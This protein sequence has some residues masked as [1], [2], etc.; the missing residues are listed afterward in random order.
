VIAVNGVSLVYEG[1]EGAHVLKDITFKAERGEKIALIG[2]NGAGKSSLLL[3]ISGVLPLHEGTISVGGVSVE[4]RNLASA[5][6]LAGLVFQ[7]P[8]D[9]LFMPTIWEDVMFGPRNYARLEPRGQAK[10]YLAKAEE[11]AEG[12]LAALGISALKS[13]VSHK[14][15]GGEKRLAALASTLV[16]EPALL[17][18]DEP[19]AFLDPK[20]RRALLSV[21][22]TLP[23]TMIVATHDLD[24]AL[25]LCNRCLL[26]AEK[27]IRADGEAAKIL[28]DAALLERFGL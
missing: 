21:L 17:L 7:N 6:R 28:S 25:N 8:D 20:G 10:A 27:T 19:T 14:L 4:R 9:Q 15:S 1:G 16:L 5:R 18:L 12:L 26:L 3:A 23:H 2:A 24:F 22:R 13:R 11:R